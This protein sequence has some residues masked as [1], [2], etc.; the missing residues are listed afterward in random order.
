MDAICLDKTNF[1]QIEAGFLRTYSYRTAQ[2]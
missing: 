2:E 1:M